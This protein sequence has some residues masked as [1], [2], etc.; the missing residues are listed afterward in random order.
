MAFE[1]AVPVYSAV[2]HH[3]KITNF[4]DFLGLKVTWRDTTESYMKEHYNIAKNAMAD[5]NKPES[6]E[7]TVDGLTPTDYQ[8]HQRTISE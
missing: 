8:P 6:Y 3:R 2:R 7:G 5:G 1:P 4:N